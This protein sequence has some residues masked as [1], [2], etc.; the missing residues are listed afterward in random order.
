MSN[1]TSTK[2]RQ[3]RYLFYYCTS[4][5]G[6]IRIHPQLPTVVNFVLVQRPLLTFPNHP[7]AWCIHLS[8]HEKGHA[9]IA[10]DYGNFL[11]FFFS[12][13]VGIESQKSLTYFFGLVNKIEN[14]TA[15]SDPS[16]HVI[17]LPWTRVSHRE[18]QL[19]GQGWQNP[20][21]LAQVSYTLV[22]WCTKWT[23]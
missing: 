20:R 1:I 11:H 4:L 8:K 21:F 12:L 10:E 18:F 5:S 22:E 2:N 7:V 16:G 13:T 14:K 9:M 23:S 15:C 3:Y 17:S 19:P 6:I